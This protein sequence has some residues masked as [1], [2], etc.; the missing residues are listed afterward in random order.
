VE[1]H[2]LIWFLKNTYKKIRETRKLESIHEK[3][4]VERKIK[5]RKP[6]KNSSLRE[7]ASLF[8]ETSTRKAVQEFHLRKY[9]EILNYCYAN[10]L[11]Q[12]VMEVT[13]GF[14][15]KSFPMSS[16]QQIWEFRTNYCGATIQAHHTL[17]KNTRGLWPQA[18]KRAPVFLLEPY[19]NSN[20]VNKFT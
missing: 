18:R 13:Q 17:M 20:F 19:R 3:L 8:P 11:R 12:F 5:G 14:F 6:D 1:N 16:G 15:K 7:D 10:F 4:F 9:R 2:N